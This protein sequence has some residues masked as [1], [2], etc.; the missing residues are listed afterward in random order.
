[1]SRPDEPA[2]DPD[3]LLDGASGD[4]DAEAGAATT[5]HRTT[6][7]VDHKRD[8]EVAANRRWMR[9]DCRK[10]KKLYYLKRI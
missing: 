8:E 9:V 2:G 10:K 1:V 5:L 3:R 7:G 4:D 6:A